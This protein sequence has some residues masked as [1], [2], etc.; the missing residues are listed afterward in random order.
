M[1]AT[2]GGSSGIPPDPSLQTGRDEEERLNEWRLRLRTIREAGTALEQTREEKTI[3]RVLFQKIRRYEEGKGEGRERGFEKI[4]RLEENVDGLYDWLI[5]LMIYIDKMV[6][7]DRGMEIMRTSRMKVV[8]QIA[9]KLRER[10]GTEELTIPKQGSGE[11]YAR[12]E[13]EFLVGVWNEKVEQRRMI[14]E[15]KVKQEN[16]IPMED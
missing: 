7:Y 13:V 14:K 6:N 12:R 9:A 10:K 4:P 1:D 11:D 16:Y 2:T 3:S 15:W 8:I 5:L